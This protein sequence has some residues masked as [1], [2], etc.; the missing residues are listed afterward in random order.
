MIRLD[1]DRPATFCDGLSRR[2]FLHAGAIAPLGLTLSELQRAKAANGKDTDV[3]C[4]MLF[5]VGG[6]SQLDT[7]DMKP[8]AP[9]EVRG[10]FKPVQTN[11][12]GMQISEIFPKMAKHADKFSLIRSVYHTA[13]AVHDTGHQMMQTGRLFTGGVEHPHIGCALGYLKGG[14]GELPAHVLLPKPIGRTGGNL[15]HGHTAGYLGKPHD[16]FILNADPNAPGFKVPDLLPPEYVSAIRAE[17]RQKLRDAVDGATD[18]FE[19]NAQSKQLD[20]NF[21]LAYKLMSSEKARNAFA[22]EKEPEKTKDRYGRTRFGQSCLMARRLIE[23]G[24][25][26]VTVNMFETVFD[27]VTWDIHGSK[28]FTDIVQMSKEVAPNFDA[29]YTALLEDLSERGLLS[30]T[31]VVALGEF[32]RTPKVNPAGGR[33]HHPGA[34]SIVIGGGPL[35]GGVVV[36]ETDELGYA[37]KSRPVTPGEVAATLYKGL[38]LDP[39]KELPGPQNRPMPMVDYGL[40]PINELF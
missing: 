8:N 31:M 11:A 12:V 33:D 34:W 28:P 6:P 27:E 24:V 5:L 30:N 16:P 3:N 2:D 9:A 32:G 10:P 7:W 1:A 40:K 13:T 17:R 15:P 37:P 19:K 23:A 21:K 14:R 36:G 29:A 35:K 38:G 22:L 4:I 18:V 25:R 26:F 20:D 39:H